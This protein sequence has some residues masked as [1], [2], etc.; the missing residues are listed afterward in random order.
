MNLAHG[1]LSG[2]W[3]QDTVSISG[4]DSRLMVIF[5]GILAI[6]VLVLVVFLIVAAMT[7]AV[8][9]RKLLA[10][11]EAA[12]G[13]ALP[14]I[15]K[16]GPMVDEV[17]GLLEHSSPKIKIIATNL[18]ETSGILKD[19]A[20][21]LSATVADANARTRSQ[22]ARVDGMVSAVLSTASDISESIMRGVK[23]PVRE[24][25]GLMNGLKAGLDVLVGRGRSNRTA[26]RDRDPGW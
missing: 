9:A 15:D 1:V 4:H 18:A 25:N 12:Q 10:L 24:F 17:H 11:A 7:A 26:P 22:V 20:Q 13:K 8:M 3:L 23:V 21:D 14:L 6:S 2:M 16:I 19:K 5:V